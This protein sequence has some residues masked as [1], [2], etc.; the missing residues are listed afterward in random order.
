MN[1]SIVYRINLHQ[2]RNNTTQ[3]VISGNVYQ[4]G[5]AKQPSTKKG[6]TKPDSVNIS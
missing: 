3:V 5:V 4:L 2:N 6:N 1:L